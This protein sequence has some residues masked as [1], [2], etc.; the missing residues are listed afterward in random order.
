MGKIKT[1]IFVTILVGVPV[2]KGEAEFPS[3][4]R[5][6]ELLVFAKQIR[7]FWLTRIENIIPVILGLFS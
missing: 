2:I 7:S 1:L 6:S 4:L 3:T 5:L